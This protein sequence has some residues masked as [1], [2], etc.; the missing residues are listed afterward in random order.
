VH[1]YGEN[2]FRLYGLPIPV[3]NSVVGLLG[4]NGTGKTT[5][6]QLLSGL[7]APNLG[8]YKNPPQWEEIL[9][10]F[11]GSELFEYLNNLKDG[12]IKSVYKI[13]RVDLL[14]TKFKGKKVKDLFP[15]KDSKIEVLFRKFGLDKIEDRNIEDLSGGEL[16]KISIVAALSKDVDF[17][18]IDEPSSYLDIKQR[19]KMAFAIKEHSEG[20]SMLVVEHDLAT[21]D[22]ISDYIHIVYGVPGAYGIISK[23]YSSRRAINTYLDGFIREENIRFREESLDFKSRGQIFKGKEIFF[24]YH[25]MRKTY[26]NSFSLEIEGGDIYRGEIIG[27]IGENALGKSSFMKILAGDLEDDEKLFKNPLKISYK[28]QYLEST[29]YSGTV[30]SYLNE[31]IKITNDL[32]LHVIKPLGLDRIMDKNIENLSGGE[33]Q[34]VKIVECLGKE[35]DIYLLDEPSAFLDVEERVNFVRVLRRFVEN[36]KKSCFVVDHDL[37][38]L[39][40]MADRAIVFKG[41]SGVHG[42]CTK[43][44]ELQDAMNEFL[45]ELG[46]TFRRDPDSGRPRANKLNSQKDREQK[47]KGIYFEVF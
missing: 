6:L 41:E 19:I 36:N 20:K 8:N 32:K 35:A 25:S 14:T 16:Q 23:K 39:N 4:P 43:P 44:K 2:T 29:N 7:F 31:R 24:S 15:N 28:P 22:M 27:V 33:M 18:F 5:S 45:K 47:E 1:Q 46:I 13:Q 10:H 3:K 21:M 34:R 11:R 40:Y 37:M 17:Y 9:K 26:Q 30:E 12:K 38:L 42:F